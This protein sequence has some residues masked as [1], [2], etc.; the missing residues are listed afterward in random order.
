MLVSIAILNYQ[1]C[2]ALRRALAAARR[3]RH[4][5]EI[6]AVDNASTDGSAEM[7]REEFPD[8]HLVALPR[9]IAAAARNTGVAAAKGDIVLTL[10]NDVELTMPD[11]VEHA[12]DAF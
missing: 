3:Q 9:N 1:R 12:L 8:V 4:P 2:D 5:V 7:V 11:D 10:D 6:I